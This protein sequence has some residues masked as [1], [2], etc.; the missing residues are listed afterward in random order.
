MIN[1]L[2]LAGAVATAAVVAGNQLSA[3]EL[4]YGTYV[5]PQHESV[6]FGANLLIKRLP[7]ETNGE[8]TYKLFTSGTMGGAKEALSSVRDGVVDSSNIVDI[9]FRADLPVTTTLSSLL[10]MPDDPRVWVA[11]M[12]EVNLLKCPECTAER[13]KNNI[14]GIA[15]TGAAN[16]YLLCNKEVGSLEA[17]KGK[18]VRAASRMGVLAQSMGAVPVSISA[19]EIYEA[20]QRGQ[21]DCVLGS[22]AWMDG[23]SLKDFVT[24]IVTTPM[25][26]YFGSMLIDLNKDTWDSLTESQQ[27]AFWKI[28]PE[29]VANVMTNYMRTNQETLDQA[30][31]NGV[32]LMQADDALV[33]VVEQARS[34]E[35][36]AVIDDAK[37]QNVAGAEAAILAFRESVEKWEGIMAKVGDDQAAYQQALWDEIFSKMA[38]Q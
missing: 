3:R 25:G 20:L 9:Y 38:S 22:A 15:W 12:N 14:V 23:Y 5:P 10:I 19:G 13:E 34:N 28:A 4:T 30:E 11:A 36:Q 31:G 18:K 8:L 21:L 16:Y 17:L 6:E 35:W 24:H 33:A 2:C 32:T 26:A 1:K 27:Q 29:L 37:A 7:E